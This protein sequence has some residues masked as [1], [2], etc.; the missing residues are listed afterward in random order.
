[1]LRPGLRH[2][3]YSLVIGVLVV[4]GGTFPLGAAE[5]GATEWL[6]LRHGGISLRAPLPTGW[7]IDEI[8]HS[9]PGYL[10]RATRVGEP[11]GAMRI[12]LAPPMR[13]HAR[14]GEPTLGRAQEHA[15]MWLGLACSGHSPEGLPAQPEGVHLGAMGRFH[16][17]M[18]FVG[19]LEGMELQKFEAHLRD[20][21]D[22]LVIVSA[23][24]FRD[25]AWRHC[26]SVFMTDAV[27]DKMLMVEVCLAQVSVA[28]DAEAQFAEALRLVRLV[29]RCAEGASLP[30]CPQAVLGKHFLID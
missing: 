1:M 9:G 28:S 23:A 30:A 6:L 26:A 19:T 5:P 11:H 14:P 22:P 7:R 21:T 16:A 24:C 17:G 29:G 12:G 2:A 10:I 13:D 15:L 25:D 8:G 4:V 18:G 20:A 27:P 3:A